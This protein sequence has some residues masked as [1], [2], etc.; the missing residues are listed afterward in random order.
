M[1][2]T[3]SARGRRGA[4]TTS[5][6]RAARARIPRLMNLIAGHGAGGE[7]RGRRDAVGVPG[8]YPG[9]VPDAGTSSHSYVLFAYSLVIE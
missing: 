3:G 1:P 9:P 4:G 2:P 6:V 5:L 7:R 8:R